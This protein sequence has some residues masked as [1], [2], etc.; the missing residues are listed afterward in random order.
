MQASHRPS[1]AFFVYYTT[2]LSRLCAAGSDA[3]PQQALSHSGQAC[4]QLGRKSASASVPVSLFG[5]LLALMCK[6]GTASLL[7]HWSRLHVL[8][9]LYRQC[10]SSADRVL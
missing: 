1:Y 5:A 8:E 6:G 10:R 3:L 4:Q 9:S 7:M 2:E